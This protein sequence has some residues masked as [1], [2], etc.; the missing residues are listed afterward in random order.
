MI[1]HSIVKHMEEN[2]LLSKNQHGFLKGR[3]TT[4]QLLSYLTECVEIVSDGGIV[5]AICFDFA[6]AFDS[7]PH[8]RLL[9]KLSA[10]GIDGHLFRWIQSFLLNRQQ[11]VKVNGTESY[12]CDVK[13]GVPQGSVLGPL[14]FVIYINDLPE[15]ISSNSYLFADDTK[16]FRQISS[17]EDAKHLQDDIDALD[18]WSKTWLFEISS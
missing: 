3:S 16:I 2:N 10:Y 9:S 6:K 14:L 4:T 11:V 13:S 17:K 12:S 8:Q 1:K 18:S 15:C 7:V 5:D